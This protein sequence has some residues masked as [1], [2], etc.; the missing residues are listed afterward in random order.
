MATA[1]E[2]V[3]TPL[4]GGESLGVEVRESR[5]ARR[6]RLTVS[7]EGPPVLVVPVGT[8]SGEVRRMLRDNRAWMERKTAELRR[9]DARRPRLGLAQ[10]GAICLHGAPVPVLWRPE[11]RPVARLTSRGLAVGGDRAGALGA[12]ER[13]YRREARERISVA[14]ERE[15]SALGVHPT[16]LSVR[17]Q[18]TRWGSCSESGALSFSWRLLLAPPEIL[19]YVVVHELCH[20]R[21]LDHSPAFWSLVAAARPGYKAHVRWLRNHGPELGTYDPSIALRRPPAAAPQAGP[22]AGERLFEV[23]PAPGEGR[24]PA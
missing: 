24:P 12:I 11:A 1:P 2:P 15:A 9:R 19:D 23:S 5:R 22:A 7:A 14:V 4:E 3:Q 21:R 6:L 16:R 17:D 8:R 13:W 18:R 20:M 10:P